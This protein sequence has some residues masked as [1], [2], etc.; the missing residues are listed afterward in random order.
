MGYLDE[1]NDL[2]D[3]EKGCKLNLPLWA[4]LPLA[5]KRIVAVQKPSYFSEK[6]ELNLSADPSVIN[7]ND[8]C[9]YFYELGMKLGAG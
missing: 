6:F 3:L 2:P 5:M 1:T 8:R 4:A 7:L 9:P